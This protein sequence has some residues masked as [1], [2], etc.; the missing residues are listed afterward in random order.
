MNVPSGV[1]LVFHSIRPGGGMERY[2]MDVI[3]ELCRRGISVRGIARKVDWH[4]APQGAEFVVMRDRTPVSRLNNLLFERNALHACRPDWKTIGISRVPGAVD[5]AIVGGTH[6]GHLHDKGKRYPGLFDR[7]TIRHETQFY[8]KAKLIM[9]HS[10]RVAGEISQLYDI[11]VS[12]VAVHYPPVDTQKFSLA[13]REKREAIRQTLGIRS[14][15]FM[16]LFPSNNHKLKGAEL[17]LQALQ[18][19]GGKVILVVAGKAPLQAPHVVNAGFCQDMP[20]L[21]AAAD[22]TILASKY[23]AFGLVGPESILCGTPVLF[24]NTIGAVEVLREPGCY[25]FGRSVDE[26]MDCLQKVVNLRE[27]GLPRSPEWVGQS[28][29]YPYSIFMHVNNLL[30][31]LG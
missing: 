11:P 19:F 18:A 27:E 16:L 30:S 4:D 10:K 23:E 8:R 1:N 29:D 26:L 28:L 14:D 31:L 24:A 25:V 6:I 21:Y 20:A 2:V 17:I 5:L 13:A 7:L 3:A 15:Q 9:P 22:A 12:K